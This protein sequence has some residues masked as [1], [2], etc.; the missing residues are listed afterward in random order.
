MLY[1]LRSCWAVISAFFNVADFADDLILPSL[2]APKQL[3]ILDIHESSHTT[4]TN[5]EGFLSLQNFL[6]RILR[7]IL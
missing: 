5:V 2:S 3:S 4:L 7:L 6:A 1:R